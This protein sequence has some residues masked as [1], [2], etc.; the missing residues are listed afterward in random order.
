MNDILEP[1][2]IRYS[3]NIVTGI[4]ELSHTR[5]VE[6]VQ[7]AIASGRPVRILYVSDFDPA[8]ISMPV[9]VARKIEFAIQAVARRVD[10]Q[11]RPIARAHEQCVDYR[12]KRIPLKASEH[13]AA[14]FEK[15]FG[16]LDMAEWPTE[17]IEYDMW[18][19]S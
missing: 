7:R 13:R 9:A 3:V 18:M 1:L 15:R 5:C 10:V 4:G 6:L 2:G 19:N 11:V 8:G 12:L 14:A 17:L 16:R